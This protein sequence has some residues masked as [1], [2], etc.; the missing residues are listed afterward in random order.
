MKRYKIQLK[1]ENFLLNFT[2]EPRK[3]GFHATRFLKAESPQDAE[4]KAI[5]M[6]R[7][8]PELRNTVTSEQTGQPSITLTA[9]REINPLL[10]LLKQSATLLSFHV[11]DEE[12]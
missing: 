8:T 1:G 12:L 3:F 5:I 4:K 6:L 2:G 11:E 7:Q 9:I 10:F